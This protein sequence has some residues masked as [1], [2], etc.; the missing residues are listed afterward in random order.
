VL[1]T[2]QFERVGDHRSIHVDV[3]VITAT[4]RDLSH[5]VSEGAFR[6]DLFFRVNVLPIHL[7]PLR[8][9]IED[10]PR[11][12][13]VIIDG[14]NRKTQKAMKGVSPDVMKDFMA[15]GWP[16]NIRELK[17]ALEYA[18]VVTESGAIQKGNLPSFFPG[19]DA[20]AMP[21]K[22]P[23][24]ARKDLAQLDKKTALVEALR[25]SRGSRTEAARLLGVHRM[26]VWNRMKKY[27]IRV[28]NRFD[29]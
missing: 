3:R 9:K 13:E 10:I 7:P 24:A 4:N 17:S 6:H 28:T 8:E 12:V 22:K 18:F 29:E 2:R 23:S 15:Y 25:L 27:D 21:E 1:E 11:L 5:M 20:N 14:L 16:G 19:G 26:T